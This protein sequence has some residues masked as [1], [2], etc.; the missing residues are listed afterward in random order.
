MKGEFIYDPIQ[1]E[2]LLG[3]QYM[4][5]VQTAYGFLKESSRDKLR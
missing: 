1:I 4:E 3:N 2:D 5:A